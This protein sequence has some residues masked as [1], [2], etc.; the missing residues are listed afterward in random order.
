MLAKLSRW[1]GWTLFAAASLH[2]QSP[3][4]LPFAADQVGPIGTTLYFDMTVLTPVTFTSLDV[5]TSSPV[6]ATGLLRL[7]MGPSTWVGAKIGRAHV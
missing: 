5:N 6:G 4:I 7:W 3:L 2:A 1:V